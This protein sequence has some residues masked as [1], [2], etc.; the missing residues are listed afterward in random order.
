M[1]SPNPDASGF[2][3][4]DS[5]G[6]AAGGYA[7]AAGRDAAGPFFLRQCPAAHI[8]VKPVAGEPGTAATISGGR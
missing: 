5:V 4:L 8:S 7:F 1:S 6:V 3:V 2:D